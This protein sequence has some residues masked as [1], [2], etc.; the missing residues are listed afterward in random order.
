[1][2]SSKAQ[3]L[4]PEIKELAT[5]DQ[6]FTLPLNNL[7]EKLKK[8]KDIFWTRGLSN[9][10]RIQ[11]TERYIWVT[12]LIKIVVATILIMISVAGCALLWK[13]CKKVQRLQVLT[14]WKQ[15]IYP[16]EETLPRLKLSN[17]QED[18]IAPKQSKRNKEIAK[19]LASDK[20]LERELTAVAKSEQ[21]TLV[22]ICTS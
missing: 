17:Y 16:E 2:L 1:M 13:M 14:L 11:G 12:Q 8:G 3:K 18:P 5:L 21:F 4:L 22:M 9:L 6:N 19:M 7:I 10:R 15:I 20:L